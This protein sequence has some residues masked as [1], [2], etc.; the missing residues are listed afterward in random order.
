MICSRCS[1]GLFLSQMLHALLISSIMPCS[2][3][4]TSLPSNCLGVMLVT[5]RGTKPEGRQVL[6]ASAIFPHA[7]RQSAWSLQLN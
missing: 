1:M 7:I 6:P 4:L 5:L 3:S 2:P